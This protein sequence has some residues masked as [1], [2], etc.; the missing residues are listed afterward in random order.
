MEKLSPVL[1]LRRRLAGGVR[2]MHRVA[3]YGGMGHSMVI[4]PRT[5]TSSCSL[6]WRSPPSGYRQHDSTHGAIGYATGLTP[7]LTLGCGT[8][9]NNITTDNVSARHLVNIKRLAFGTRA[10]RFNCPA[11]DRPA[12]AP[13]VQLAG[14]ALPDRD[15]VRSVVAQVIAEMSGP[16]RRRNCRRGCPLAN[17]RRRRPR[18]RTA[19]G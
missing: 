15:R 9:G 5:R 4:H 1:A 2:E 14:S 18:R 13:P 7:S 12:A 3:A 6:P 19:A 10:I 17:R 16:P 11:P 8:W